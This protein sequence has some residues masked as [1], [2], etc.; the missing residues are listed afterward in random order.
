MPSVNR[1]KLKDLCDVDS[2]P[3][4]Q[5]IS[6]SL[7]VEA[8]RLLAAI[9]RNSKHKPRGRRWNFEEKILALSLLKRSPKS[10]ILLQTLFP[11]PSE[12]TLQSLLN[13]IPFRTGIN[14]PVFDAL[15][16]SLQ[17]MYQK[18]RYCFLLFNEMSIR[19]NVWFNQKFDCTEGFEDL[20]SQGRTC[21]I[22]NHALLFM[23]R[24]LHWKWKQPV[25]YYLSRG[26]T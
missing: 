12:C 17:K 2:D 19:E 3:L 15:R 22:A 6:N 16:H 11:L 25:A 21:N 8:V 7:N 14:T 23:V 1:K 18:D 4:M 13:T 26:S 20:G 10:Y 9:I 24:G 5:E